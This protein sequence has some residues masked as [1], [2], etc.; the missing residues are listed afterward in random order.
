[1]VSKPVVCLNDERADDDKAIEI[2]ECE[3]VPKEVKPVKG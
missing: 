3:L 1:M 2:K